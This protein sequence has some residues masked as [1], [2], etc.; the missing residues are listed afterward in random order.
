[1]AAGHTMNRLA[2]ILAVLL[3]GACAAPAAWAENPTG[4][5][6][7][8]IPGRPAVIISGGTLDFGI[9][10]GGEG[11]L[12]LSRGGTTHPVTPG[13]RQIT[14]GT[15]RG[16]AVLA[17]TLAAGVYDLVYTAGDREET[18]RGAVH[19][20]TALPPAYA[21]A[22]VRVAA[23]AADV[24]TQADFGAVGERIVASG[25]ALAFLMGP[26]SPEGNAEAYPAL[27]DM[28]ASL[29]VP[30]YVVPSER[31][32]A[33]PEYRELFGTPFY[34]MAYGDDGYLMLG[35]GLPAAEATVS[36]ALGSIYLARRALR[37]S[38]WTIGVT[39]RF[40]LDWHLRSQIA[41]FVDDP[42][43][44][45]IAAEVPPEMGAEVPWGQTRLLPPPDIPRGALMMLDV[46]AGGIRLRQ[47]AKQQ[48]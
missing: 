31:E 40:G 34:G 35:A 20:V 25:A 16:Q 10:G 29:P 46:D 44:Y 6:A 11:S 33:A 3:A 48:P 39:G 26:L 7:W 37:A 43:D 27:Q 5:I 9:K 42:L 18:Q 2:R 12:H 21:V 19:V 47:E 30:A 14:S 24:D 45:L 38:R 17:D 41:L 36:R 32:L 15:A 4:A 13:E 23:F 28:L 22:V 8:P 1:M